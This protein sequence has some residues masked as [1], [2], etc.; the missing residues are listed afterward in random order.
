MNEIEENGE[1]AAGS[2]TGIKT[3]NAAGQDLASV[4]DVHALASERG[5][6]RGTLE[7]R[8]VETLAVEREKGIVALQ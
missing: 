8:A 2:V 4:V 3:G 6:E 7:M 1:N 5:T